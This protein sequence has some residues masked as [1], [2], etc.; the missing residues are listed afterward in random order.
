MNTLTITLIIIIALAIIIALM[1]NN[2]VGLN[3]RCQNAW[4]QIDNQLKRR[5]DLIPNLVEVTKGYAAHERETLVNVVNARNTNASMSEMAKESETVSQ[6]V[7]NLLA[8]AEKYPDLKANELFKN[9]QIE[10]TG[11][12]DKIAFARQF[13]N[14]TVQRFNT[15]ISV[16]PNNIVANIMHYQEKEYFKVDDNEKNVVKVEL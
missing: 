7:K 15:A 4:S 6:N 5:Y 8:V 10:L 11:T 9:L 12:E 2:L 13:Y 1:F 16:F 14:D 3:I